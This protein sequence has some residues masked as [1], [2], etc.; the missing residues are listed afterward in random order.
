MTRHIRTRTALAVVAACMAIAF[1]GVGA[2][3]AATAVSGSVAGA[4]TSVAGTTFTL[5]TTV[6]GTGSSKVK[7]SSKSAIT[8]QVAGTRANL[9]TG[10]C[11][12]ASGT[13]SGTAVEAAQIVI[14]GVNATQC[15]AGFGGTGAPRQPTGSG[16]GGFTP[17][18]NGGF[19]FGTISSVKGSTLTVTGRFGAK[20]VLVS[21]K[22]SILKTVSAKAAAIT[23][24]ECAFVRGTSSDNGVTLN[25]SNVSLSAPTKDGCSARPG[26]A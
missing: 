13:A 17:S 11:V 14:T 16:G 24:K 9:K 5:K 1:V 3:G 23:V 10:D 12:R 25:A 18:G 20:S 26:R 6:T 15:S 21:S 2:V 22:T 7:L 4:V 8:K 19:A